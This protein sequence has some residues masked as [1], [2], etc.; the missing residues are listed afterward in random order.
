MLCWR[1][2]D[3]ELHEKW[4]TMEFLFLNFIGSIYQLG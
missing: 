3:K 4:K 2:I 1:E